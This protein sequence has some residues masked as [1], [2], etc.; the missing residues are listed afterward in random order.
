MNSELSRNI[1]H[2]SKIRNKYNKWRSRENYIEWQTMK[3]KCKK[4]ANKAEKDHFESIISKGIMTNKEFWEKVKPALSEHNP[5]SNTNIILQ[6]GNELISDDNKISEILNN[7]YINIVE[8]STG[9]APK[10]LGEVNV[11]DKQSVIE[12]INK[13]VSHYNEHPSI[14]IIKDN[15]QDCPAFKIPLAELKD[16]DMIL[17]DLNVK[18]S[19]GPDLLPPKLIKLVKDIINQPLTDV[20]N[21]IIVSCIFSDNGKVAHVTPGFKTDKKDRQNKSHYRPI[22][23]IGVFSKIVERYIEMKINEHI[24]SLLSVFI[25]AYRK[26]YSTNHVLMRLIENWKFHLDNKKIVGAV[27]M[28]LSKAFDCVPHD[29]LIAKMHAYGFDIDTLVLMF[30]YLKNRQQGVKVNNKIHSFMTLVSGVPQGSILGPIL[31]NLFINDITLFFNESDLYNYADDNTISTFANTI[32]E[33]IETLQSESEIAI[34]W[35]N[36]NEMIVNPDKFQAIIIDRNNK[37]DLNH[38]ILKFNDYEITSSN[39]VVLLGIEIDDKLNFENHTHNLVRKSAGQLNYLISKQRFLSQ[40]AKKI[41]IESFIM[42]NFN[43]CPLVWLFCNKKLK[44][45]QEQIQK[46]ALRFLYNDYESDYEHLLKISDRPS[47]EIKHLRNLATEIFKTLNDLNPPF[48]KEIFTL[49]SNRDT[50][51]MKLLVK[52]QNTKRYGTNTL[53][54]MGPKI[55]NNL[56]TEQKNAKNLNIFKELIKTWSGPECGCNACLNG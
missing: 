15:Y 46:R 36:D 53:R 7:Q 21:H 33:L 24:E 27:L 11:S 13:I 6:E 14:K 47:I 30:S 39:S 5:T 45:K 56:S 34:K 29:L 26:K 2:K 17:K 49:N 37:G 22:S 51:R 42:A 28:D 1:K 23:V 44:N 20:I 12:Y 18:K 19:P 40:Q 9:S 4:L 52:T 25:A 31:F 38:H 43:Y 35:F 3:Y 48:M 41:L 55:W 10:T 54:S 16:I 8:I 50:S 32:K